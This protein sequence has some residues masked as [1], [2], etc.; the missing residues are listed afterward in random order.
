MN[1]IF[2]PD[3]KKELNQ[4]VD[5]YESCQFG[6]RRKKSDLLRCSN[7][8]GTR[9]TICIVSHLKNHYALYIEIFT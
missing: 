2:H 8:S 5:Y 6:W 7:F 9:H 4:G 1:F 3:A